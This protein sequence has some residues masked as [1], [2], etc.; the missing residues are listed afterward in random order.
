MSPTTRR[1]YDVRSGCEEVL[2]N[3]RNQYAGH[4]FRSLESVL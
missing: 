4:N 3:Q 2:C 1:V